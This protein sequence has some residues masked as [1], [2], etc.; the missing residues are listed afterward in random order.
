[1]LFK[2]KPTLYDILEIHSQASLQEIQSAYARMKLTFQE[3][4]I[5]VYSLISSQEREETLKNITQAYFILSDPIKRQ[6]YDQN[7]NALTIS[8]SL[9]ILSSPQTWS[10]FSRVQSKKIMTLPPELMQRIQHETQWSGSFLKTIREHYQIS[11]ED[12]AHLT[13]LKKAYLKAIEEENFFQLPAS[14]Y[15]RGFITQ[16]A[17]ILKIPPETVADAYMKR[18]PK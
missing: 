8:S 6:I 13:K 17:K 3:N 10:H 15:V 14:A 9:E 18:Y 1:M 7:L 2:S 11:L 16:I 5:A 12:L 4:N